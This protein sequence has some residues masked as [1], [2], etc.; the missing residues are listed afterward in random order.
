MALQYYYCEYC[1]RKFTNVRSM[2][3]LRCPHHPNGENKGFHKMYEGTEKSQYTCKYCGRQFKT[4]MELTRLNC[5]RHPNGE[6]KGR[7]GVAL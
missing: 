4:I 6:N 1:G 2:S 7:H 3:G 5:H